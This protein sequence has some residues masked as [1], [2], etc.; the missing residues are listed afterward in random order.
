MSH[1]PGIRWRMDMPQIG[2]P[3]QHVANIKAIPAAA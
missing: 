2:A 1:S 3:V